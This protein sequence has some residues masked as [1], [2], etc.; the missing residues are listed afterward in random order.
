MLALIDGD[1]LA[2]M[3]CKSRWV[4]DR[5]QR[6]VVLDKDAHVFSKAEDRE[7][8]EASWENFKQEVIKVTGKC[9]TNH[10]LMAVKH[11]HNYRN[12]IYSEYK[13]NRHK[14][15]SKQNHFVPS[16]R[17][18]AV[19]EELAIEAIGRE[20]DD[21]LCIWAH[22]AM[23]ANEDYTI[24]SIDKD[25]KCIPGKHY[26]PKLDMHFSVTPKEALRFFYAQL[27]SGDPTDNIPGLPGIG[28][29]KA[30]KALFNT[31]TEEDMQEEVVA[32]YMS[33]F[34]DDWYDQLLSNGKMLYLQKHE[35][36]YFTC[37]QWPV[38]QHFGVP[39]LKK[40]QVASACP[41]DAPTEVVASLPPVAPEKL[42]SAPPQQ[43]PKV[44]SVFKGVIPKLKGR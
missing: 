28:P 37:Y 44:A 31:H 24:V 9:W 11:K 27:L 42:D 3:G 33:F 6:L 29:A 12:D 2:Y 25:L 41:P 8:M 17:T 1:V 10:Y 16:I 36:D 43:S 20:A 21:L 18:L 15:P 26:N 35:F 23:A 32:M 14:D 34:G 7:Y 22:Q 39:A 19:I 4:N 5:N 30:E 13:M 38:V 40:P